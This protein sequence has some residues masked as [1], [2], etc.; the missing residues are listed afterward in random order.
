MGSSDHQVELHWMQPFSA[1]KQSF[2]TNIAMIG[3]IMIN[4]KL[5]SLSCGKTPLCLKAAN[6]ARHVHVSGIYVKQRNLFS[7]TYSKS[8]TTFPKVT[9]HFQK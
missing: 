1:A 6:Y 7:S 5:S 8:N 3:D 2:D 9:L 4:A